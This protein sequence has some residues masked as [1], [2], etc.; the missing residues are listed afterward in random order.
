MLCIPFLG[1]ERKIGSRDNEYEENNRV[2]VG[3]GVLFGP[4][5]AVLRKTIGGGVDYGRN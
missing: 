1:N 2:A 4:Y 5:E 3:K